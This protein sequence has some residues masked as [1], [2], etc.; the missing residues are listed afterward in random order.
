LRG[1]CPWLSVRVGSWE[2][3]DLGLST[4][5]SACCA[6]SGR[7]AGTRTRAP[8]LAS[9]QVVARPRPEAPPVTTAVLPVRSIPVR[10]SLAV[11]AAPNGLRSGSVIVWLVMPQTLGTR[12]RS[13]SNGYDRAVGDVGL[14][15][16][17]VARR[18]GLS[19]H[20]LRLYERKGLLAGHVRHDQSGRRVYS[21]RDIEWL[22][23]CVKVRASG[24]P[25]AAISRLAEVAHIGTI[26]I[27][28]PVPPT[29]LSGVQNRALRLKVRW[30]A[31]CDRFWL[32]LYDSYPPYALGCTMPG[33]PL[34][35]GSSCTTGERSGHHARD[36]RCEPGSR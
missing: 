32:S 5:A 8:A 19:V 2:L 29:Q 31:F 12:P 1:R 24:M 20:T 10:T 26:C 16:G 17:E 22:A 28:L 35:D 3:A 30:V 13:R 4:P 14:S 25:L 36:L 27:R 11:L 21:A 15:I 23:N 9:A 34:L 6:V 7:R 18:T 33:E